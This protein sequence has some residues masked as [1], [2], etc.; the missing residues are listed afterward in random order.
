M[1][2]SRPGVPQWL[3]YAYGGRLGPRYAQWVL[4]D[5]TCRT[6]FVRHLVRTLAQTMPAWLLLLLPGPLSLTMLLPVF[7]V[8]GAEY[9][10]VSFADEMRKYRLY[11]H[12]F[13]PE[14]V[15]PRRDD[16]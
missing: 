15:L 11:Q 2:S 10:A 12:G 6:W 5:L 1:A 7:V 9:M 3:Y 13:P 14:M 4:R 8:V 16:D